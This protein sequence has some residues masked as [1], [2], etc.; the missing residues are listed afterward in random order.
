MSAPLLQLKER[1]PSH[2]DKAI[3]GHL[4]EKPDILRVVY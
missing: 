2:D 3:K 1:R 4:A